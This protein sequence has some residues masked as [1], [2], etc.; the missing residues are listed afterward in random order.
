MSVAPIPVH[1]VPMEYIGGPLCGRVR[2]HAPNI[3]EV[4]CPATLTDDRHEYVVCWTQQRGW[5]LA[6]TG[7]R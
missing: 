2:E 6:Y 4:S 5:W 1:P 7:C 3:R